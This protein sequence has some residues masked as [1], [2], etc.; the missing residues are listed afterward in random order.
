M[1]HYSPALR[2]WHW[3]H[4]VAITGLLGTFFLRKTFLSWREN[5]ALI[6]QKMDEFGITVA[7]DQAK[8]IAV[9]IRAPMWEWHII[10]GWMLALLLLW[11]AG[12]VLRGGFGYERAQDWHM[13]LV[14]VGYFG[15]YGV[16]GFMALSGM[17][18]HYGGDFGLEKAMLGQI[19]SAHEFLAWAV[20]AFVPLH[21]I[22]V[23][24]AE[25]RDQKGVTSRMI[26][27]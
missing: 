20:A 4:A 22:G 13:R 12:M 7:P 6:A 21:V 24:V 16:L 3:L 18:L 2:L 17:A 1:R 14:H 25:H 15:L 23:V 8:A 10:F 11:R 5:S 27:G 19:K 26:S 9:A